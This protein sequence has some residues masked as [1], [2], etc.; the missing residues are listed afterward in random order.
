MVSHSFE[1]FADYFQFYLQDEQVPGIH[2]DAWTR[3]QRS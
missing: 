3:E 1:L 2:G